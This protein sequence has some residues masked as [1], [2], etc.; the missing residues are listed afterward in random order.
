MR[1][2]NLFLFRRRMMHFYE[3]RFSKKIQFC[4]CN[5]WDLP[6]E[7]EDGNVNDHARRQMGEGRYF[8]E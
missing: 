1:N 7:E 5:L 8:R 3:N 2:K 6:R 4:L